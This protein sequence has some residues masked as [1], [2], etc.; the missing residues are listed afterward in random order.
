[1]ATSPEFSAARIVGYAAKQINVVDRL[2]QDLKRTIPKIEGTKPARAFG[3]YSA[4]LIAEHDALI[5]LARADDPTTAEVDEIVENLNWALAEDRDGARDI[6]DGIDLESDEDRLN[7]GKFLLGLEKYT[8]EPM[9]GDG[10]RI[11]MGPEMMGK[12]ERD[13]NTEKVLEEMRQSLGLGS[14]EERRRNMNTQQLHYLLGDLAY[15]LPNELGNFLNLFGA[16]THEFGLELTDEHAVFMS[17]FGG[18]REGGTYTNIT[19][20]ADML[21][22]PN[23]TLEAY[24]KLLTGVNPLEAYM[25]AH[26]PFTVRPDGVE[27]G[28]VENYISITPAEIMDRLLGS[29]EGRKHLTMYNLQR[30]KDGLGMLI[31]ILKDKYPNAKDEDLHLLSD[32]KVADRPT[33]RWVKAKPLSQGESKHY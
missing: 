14:E 28:D 18:G 24:Q 25:V 8:L 10:E 30:E 32:L 12:F 2:S 20:I 17:A 31:Q 29:A 26:M 15:V 23:M 21:K 11:A 22:N 5:E 7:L 6:L 13:L 19:A 16:R 33:K 4:E 3:G 27:I 1:M 9:M